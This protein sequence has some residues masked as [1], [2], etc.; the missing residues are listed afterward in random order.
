MTAFTPW[1]ARA[2]AQVASTL[3]SGRLGHALL[4]HGPAMLGKREVVERLAQ[5]AL[6]EQPSGLEPCGACRSCRL[7]AQRHQREPVETRPDGRLAHP[8]GHAT[9]PDATFI[10]HVFNERSKKMRA[11]IT[12]EQIRDLSSQLA[13]T[14]QY[15]RAQVA[16]V[17]PADAINTSAANALL[18]TLEEPVPGRYLWLVTAHPSRLPATIRS[19]CQRVEFHLPPAV[20]ARAWLLSQGHSASDVDDALRAAEGHPGLAD[21]WLREGGLDVRRRVAADLQAIARGTATPQEVA[22]AW[23][24]GQADLRLRFAAD[25]AVERARGLTAPQATR[26]LA[27]WFDKANRSRDLLRTTVR[28]DLVLMELLTA[29]R[30]TA[31]AGQ[32]IRER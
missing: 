28:A 5:R 17:D 24:D 12:I 23:A 11:E 29:W 30:A 9:H 22:A 13:L 26:S 19:R 18:K 3:E 25:L 8:H 31:R 2:Y 15:G 4:F 14:P 21:A 20:E 10:G 16:I 6:C 27:T 1:Q 7:F 32:E